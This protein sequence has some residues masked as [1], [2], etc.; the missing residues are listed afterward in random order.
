MRAITVCLLLLSFDVLAGSS[1]SKK[2]TSK[3]SQASALVNEVM[4]GSGN[5]NSIVNRIKILGEES[6]AAHELGSL[7][8]KEPNLEKRRLMVQVVAGLGHSRGEEALV[9]A[10]DDE[11]APVRM[12]AAQGLGRVR[13][14]AAG[15][16]LAMALA[17]PTLGVRRDA[18]KALGLLSDP[19]YGPVLA[20]AVKAEDDP[21]TRAAMLLALGQTGDKRQVPVLETFLTNSSESAR[22]GAAAGLCVIG[23]PSGLKFAR[24]QLAS[25]DKYERMQG[26]VLFEGSRAKDAAPVLEPLLKDPDRALQAAAARILFQGGDKTMLDW[27][28][29]TSFQTLGEDRLP[30]EK[31]LETLRLADDDRRAIL[32]KAGIQ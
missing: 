30:Y 20:K 23:A 22:F 13:S 27:L 2:A 10:L 32:R 29:L 6:Y 8:L 1:A 26:L 31:E 11:D 12:Y 16:K 21:E 7:L 25:K 19:S 14:K 5:P 9:F 17:D 28:V 3:R 15:P 24:A 18:A 4:V